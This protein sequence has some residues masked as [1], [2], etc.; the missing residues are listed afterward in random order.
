MSDVK[1]N[2]ILS[3]M[4]ALGIDPAALGITDPASATGTTRVKPVSPD[5]VVGL[6]TQL[7][8]DE[9]LE[10][11]N[12]LIA[13]N[14]DR[15]GFSFTVHELADRIMRKLPGITKDQIIAQNYLDIEETYRAQG[16]IVGYDRPGYDE[17]YDANFK[18]SVKRS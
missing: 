15:Q 9:V 14:Y 7:L 1:V 3:F 10:A 16:W 11:A 4:K 13:E 2:E 5:D 12:E 17:T 18:F 8:P 6:K